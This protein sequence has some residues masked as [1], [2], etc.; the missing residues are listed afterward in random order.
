MGLSF[1]RAG[2]VVANMNYRLAPA[3]PFP[4][5]FEDV[6][7]AYQ[8][9]LE[10][11]TDYGGD[12]SKIVLAGESAGA[13]LVTGLTIALCYQRREPW[14]KAA[15]QLDVVPKAVLAACGLLQVRDSARFGRR[16]QLPRWVNE[17]L[18]EVERSYLGASDMSEDARELAN[19]LVLLEQGDPPE[20]PLPPFFTP[21]G[22]RDPV[23][24]DTRRL[25]AA[26]DRL[27]VK[28]ETRYYDGEPHAFHAFAWREPARQCWRDTFDFLHE[29]VA[30]PLP[31]A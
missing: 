10:H 3:H 28:C 17:H 6:R 25:K 15:W 12:P 16:K 29:H 23:L 22:T 21:V 14:A 26:L 8:W 5:A 4:A 19:P 31:A 20:R 11:A 30:R 24:D 18:E 27:G 7:C 2:F 1:A 13:N 9:L